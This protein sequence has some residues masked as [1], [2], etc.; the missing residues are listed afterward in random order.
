MWLVSALALVVVA[1][2]P[3]PSSIGIPEVVMGVLAV[4]LA[5]HFFF[6]RARHVRLSPMGRMVGLSL[7]GYLAVWAVAA[8]V[9]TVRGTEM[10]AILRSLLPQVLFLP[11]ALVGLSIESEEDERALR[12][13]V[14]WPG[15]LHGL[16]LVGLGVLAYTGQSSATDLVTSRITFLDTRTTMPLFLVLGP[17]G[18]A[19]I[20]EGSMRAKVGGAALFGICCAAALAT[21]TRA[22]ILAIVIG[23]LVFGVCFVLRRPTVKTVALVLMLVLCGGLFIAVVPPLRNLAMAVVE[24]QQSVGDN[25]RIDDEW[26]PALNQ[27]EASGP[28]GFWFGIGLGQTVK[29]FSGEEKTYIHNQTI[30]SMVYTGVVG[31]A[32]TV[33][34]YALTFGSLVRRFWRD[35]TYVDLAMAACLASLWT[36]GQLF[37]VHKLFSFNLVLFVVA[38][39]AL[40]RTVG[41]VRG[42]LVV[43][44]GGVVAG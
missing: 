11:I 18:L 7:V 27:W 21:Q 12:G 33:A 31:T 41:E 23:C 13:T 43:P 3:A 10:M 28:E 20:V 6:V 40:R 37:A 32:L 42:S 36:Y 24:R 16:Y 1:A 17:I 25:A 9:G 19:M 44:R 34:F 4:A 39:F 15:L 30:Y 5:A 35:R 29:D 14:L 22:Q 2:Y 8:L 26:M 38:A